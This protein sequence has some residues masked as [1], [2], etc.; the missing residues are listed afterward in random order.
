MDERIERFLLD[1]LEDEGKK[2]NVVRANARCYVS[3]YIETFRAREVDEDKKEAAAQ[4]CRDSCQQRVLEEL[5]RPDGTP[6]ADHLR[7]VLSAIGGPSTDLNS[8][9]L[10]PKR[11]PNSSA[12]DVLEGNRVLVNQTIDN[13]AAKVHAGENAPANTSASH[14]SAEF[15]NE[16]SASVAHTTAIPKQ[17]PSMLR[18]WFASSWSRFLC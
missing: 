18:D 6:T 2:S 4:R 12:G 8:T 10:S 7:I 9:M 11:Q 16:P 15:V 17:R 13:A 3:L 5:K 1:V 14:R